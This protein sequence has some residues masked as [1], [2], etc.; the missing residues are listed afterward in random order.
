MTGTVNIQ[1][2]DPTLADTDDD[3]LLDGDEVNFYET[4]PLFTNIPGD[5]GPRGDLDGLLNA[6][7]LV[8]LTRLVTGQITAT[9]GELLLG[10]LNYNEELDVGDLLL[11]QRAVLGLIPAP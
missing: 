7:D 11:L 6:G 10:D 2:T 8:V 5:L 1:G 9:Q 3:G 4:D